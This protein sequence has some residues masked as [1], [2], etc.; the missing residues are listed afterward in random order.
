MRLI[1]QT[2]GSKVVG[3][4]RQRSPL[5]EL[6]LLNTKKRLEWLVVLYVWTNLAHL[7]GDRSLGM[8]KSLSIGVGAQRIC[9][10]G[11][12]EDKLGPHGQEGSSTASQHCKARPRGIDTACI[13]KKCL[14]S[15]GS[16]TCEHRYS[17]SKASA[18]FPSRHERHSNTS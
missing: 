16:P 1:K 4:Q 10:F 18:I 2:V 15:A 8:T 7:V 9:L 5:L 14:I 17:T 12:A 11:G 3:P 13:T 6:H